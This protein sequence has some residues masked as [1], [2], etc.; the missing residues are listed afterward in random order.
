MCFFKIS[1]PEHTGG[2][3]KN[4]CTDGTILRRLDGI[5]LLGWYGLAHDRGRT[6]RT[7]NAKESRKTLGAHAAGDARSVVDG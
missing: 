4:N 1:R 5:V 2:C 6:R 3:P 7:V